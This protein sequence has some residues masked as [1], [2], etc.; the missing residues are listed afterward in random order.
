MMLRVAVTTTA[1]GFARWAGPLSDQ[2]FEP[3]AL[4]CITIRPT[5]DLARARL[6]AVGADL[7]VLTSPRTVRFLWPEGGMPST[8]VAA[9]G[10]A[11]S[12]AV[13]EAGGEV[14]L[15]GDGDADAVVDGLAGNVAGRTVAF[16]GAASADPARA[17]RLAS[18][19]AD[20]LT[21]AVYETFPIPPATETVDAACFGSPSAVRGWSISRTF[22]ELDVVAAIGPVTAAE[23]ERHGVTTLVQPSV[24]SLEALASALSATLER[25]P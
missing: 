19:G 4:P 7:L 6:H 22:E 12:E 11:T 23:L 25:S 14:A 5:M 10:R 24:P 2:G 15:T 21:V 13:I 17:A 9:V 20:V 16:L 18:F 1:D 3:V 8:P